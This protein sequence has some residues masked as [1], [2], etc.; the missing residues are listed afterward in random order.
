MI[1]FLL[2]EIGFNVK[3]FLKLSSIEFNIIGKSIIKKKKNI[4]H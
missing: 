1:I 2:Y 3:Y 4:L